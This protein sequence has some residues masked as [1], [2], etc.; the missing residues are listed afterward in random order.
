MTT[1]RPR[2]GQ[3]GNQNARRHGFYSQALDEA[4]RL[5]LEAAQ[6]IDG[7]DA[8]IAVLRVKI[9]ALLESDPDNIKLIM[10]ATSTLAR[11]LRTR[12]SL[13]EHEGKGIE[14]AIT[15]VL[16]ELAPPLCLPPATKPPPDLSP[17]PGPASP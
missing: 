17:N 12:Y 4:Q 3:K 6:G 11:L 9:K 2:G 16:T 13:T 14:A 5:D 8:E 10:Q 1:K 7:L 15:N